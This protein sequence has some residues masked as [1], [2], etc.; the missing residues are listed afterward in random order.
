VTVV[1]TGF[2]VERSEKPL[3]NRANANRIN[4]GETR[5]LKEERGKN[6]KKQ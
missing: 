3:V 4:I 5:Q 6:L 2:D 1:A